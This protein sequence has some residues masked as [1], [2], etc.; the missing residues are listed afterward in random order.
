MYN[1]N[2]KYSK[3]ETK[4]TLL[5]LDTSDIIGLA[6]FFAEEKP[7]IATKVTDEGF[8]SFDLVVTS[9]DHDMT[10]E[11]YEELLTVEKIYETIF[12]SVDFKEK[13]DSWN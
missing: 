1:Q 5:K 9:P 7:I 11:E 12:N 6:F 3:F 13:N 8:A 4:K 2:N 10:F